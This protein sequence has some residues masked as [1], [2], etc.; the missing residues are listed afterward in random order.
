MAT[1]VAVARVLAIS[2]FGLPGVRGADGQHPP[3]HD[4]ERDLDT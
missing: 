4:V 3:F 1:S 2:L